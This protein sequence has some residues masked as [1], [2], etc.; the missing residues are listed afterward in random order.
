MLGKDFDLKDVVNES[1]VYY[2]E[3]V[4]STTGYT[5]RKITEWA[6]DNEF[7]Q[8]VKE[9]RRIKKTKMKSIK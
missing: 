5:P 1:L 8:K 4:Y 6:K 3:S 2:N 7:I 9:N